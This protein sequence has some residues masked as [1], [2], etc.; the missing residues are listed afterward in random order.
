MA[1]NDEVSVYY[2]SEE[3]IVA[4][5]L[6]YI[7]RNNTLKSFNEIPSAIDYMNCLSLVSL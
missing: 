4:K 3:H 2:D 6:K 7:D 1:T 5:G